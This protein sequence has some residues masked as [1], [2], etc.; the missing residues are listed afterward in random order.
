[1]EGRYLIILDISMEDFEFEIELCATDSLI[2]ALI[3]VKALKKVNE[4]K[5]HKSFDFKKTASDLDEILDSYSDEVIDCRS[6]RDYL[7][8]LNK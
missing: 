1:M 3:I 2:K 8:K 5:N 7:E 4:N 6:M